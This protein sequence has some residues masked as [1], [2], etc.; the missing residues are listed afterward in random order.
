MQLDYRSAVLKSFLSLFFL[1]RID[2]KNSGHD[3]NGLLFEKTDGCKIKMP[4]WFQQDGTGYQLESS[5]QSLKLTFRCQGKG[6]LNIW[7][8]GLDVRDSHRSSI[9][10]YVDYTYFALNGEV[11]LNKSTPIW[12]D[13]PFV[14]SRAVRDGD[15]Y[16]MEIRWEPHGCSKAELLEMIEKLLV[17]HEAHFG[18]VNL[19]KL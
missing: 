8:R 19:A 13:K 2:L 12:H 4:Q 5:E 6:T 1:A 16:T 9:P 15:E 3:A 11:L 7:L 17:D 18:V 10:L 14:V